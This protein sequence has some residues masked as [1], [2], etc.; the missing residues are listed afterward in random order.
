MKLKI[1][2]KDETQKYR[3]VA[4]QQLLEM[5]KIIGDEVV[6]F[7]PNLCGGETKITIYESSIPLGNEE[8]I[9]RLK[10]LRKEK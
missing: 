6:I 2:E 7:V 8:N 5:V 1:E 3:P 10:Q 9:K 4:V